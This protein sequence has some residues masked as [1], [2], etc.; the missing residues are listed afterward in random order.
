MIAF[1]RWPPQKKM[2]R[3]VGCFTFEASE[4]SFA[5]DAPKTGHGLS[6]FPAVRR[7]HGS[8]TGF[9]ERKIRPLLTDAP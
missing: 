4:A 5:A 2:E 3:L 9:D 7:V 1:F 6:G 8:W